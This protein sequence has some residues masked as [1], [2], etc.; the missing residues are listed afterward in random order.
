GSGATAGDDP[1]TANAIT[2]AHGEP[3][4][5]AVACTHQPPADFRPGEDLLLSVQLDRD[6]PVESVHCWYRRVNQAERFQSV[7][8]TRQGAALHGVI[9]SAYTTS[10]FP[11][12][13][14]FLVRL[15]PSSATIVPGLGTDLL[16]Q[17]YVV[18]RQRD[19]TS[20]TSHA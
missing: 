7:E 17:P 13:Y 12:Q 6:S 9:P 2:R 8:M 10:G 15:S 19:R 4:R 1:R 11:L 3:Q 18:L 14:Y 20:G 16:N 5:P